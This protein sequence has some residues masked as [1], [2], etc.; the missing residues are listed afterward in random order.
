MQKIM[1][2]SEFWT[3]V[4]LVG[5]LAARKFG[6]LQTAE[7]DAFF[8]PMATYVVARLVSKTAKATFNGGS[9]A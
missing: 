9:N 6:L 2:A 7:F 4:A 5:L 8:V 3:A 1:C